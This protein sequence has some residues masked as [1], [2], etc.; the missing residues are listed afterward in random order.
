MFPPMF[1][2]RRAVAA[3]VLTVACG[4]APLWAQNNIFP[5]SGFAGIGITNPAAYLHIQGQD[6]MPIYPSL[7]FGYGVDFGGETGIANTAAVPSLLVERG[8]YF[9]RTTNRSNNLV[10]T[11][12]T[13]GGQI[14]FG[15]TLAVGST[16]VERESFTISS[17][18]DAASQ[19]GHT[20]LDVKTG[21]GEGNAVLRFYNKRIPTPSVAPWMM[22][23]D[24]HHNLATTH[25]I[26]PMP[27]FRIGLDADPASPTFTSNQSFLTILRDGRVI[28]GKP[29]NPSST[30]FSG[31]FN[32]KLSVNGRIVANELV[33]VSIDSWADFVFA[34]D[35][36][37][38]SLEEVEQHIQEHK[39]LPE[40][41]SAAEVSKQGVNV[42]E[43]QAKLLQKVEELTL[44]VIEQNKK[45]NE[46]NKKI[47]VLESELRTTRTNNEGAQR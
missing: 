15:T 9:M 2:I 24:F 46:Q 34:E 26:A 17:V 37:L 1:S 35:Y 29:M 23:L 5:T 40:I 43:M 12:Q 22:G 3:L 28:I 33:C 42:V 36:K 39:H 19:F 8:D 30:H 13:P 16:P 32:S 18:Q 20:Q 21:G 14:R 44:Y 6:G 31:L 41:P 47:G 10:L 11:A 25:G 7:L 27:V 45:I 4:V 38:P